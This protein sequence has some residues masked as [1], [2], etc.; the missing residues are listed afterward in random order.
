M[1]VALLCRCYAVVSQELL[2][3][4][5]SAKQVGRHPKEHI[6]HSSPFRSCHG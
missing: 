1:T 3:V 5:L 4:V 6:S 2:L